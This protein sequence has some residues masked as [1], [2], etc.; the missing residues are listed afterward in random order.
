MSSLKAVFENVAENIF[1]TFYGIPDGLAAV[2]EKSVQTIGVRTM[3]VSSIKTHIAPANGPCTRPRIARVWP[4]AVRTTRS[5]V[6][7]RDVY[8]D[9]SWTKIERSV[10]YKSGNSFGRSPNAQ[11]ATIT[12]HSQHETR[13]TF[14]FCRNHSPIVGSSDSSGSQ[15]N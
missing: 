1:C 10:I 6:N 5:I 11:T 12:I 2:R 13:F 8:V 14:I 15:R 7:V 4:T 3:C 9:N